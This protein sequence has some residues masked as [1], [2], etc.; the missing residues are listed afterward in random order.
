MIL[1]M[2]ILLVV[3]IK[4]HGYTCVKKTSRWIFSLKTQY[5]DGSHV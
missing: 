3:R 5:V 2:K 1:R 4:N